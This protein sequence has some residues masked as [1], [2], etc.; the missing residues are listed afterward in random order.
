MCG[1]AGM[2]SGNAGERVDAGVIHR[3]CQAIVHRGPDDEGI[4][5]KD[6]VGLGMRRL[7]IIDIS[8]G[9]QPVFN[10]DRT[11]WVVY[12]GEV[13]NFPELRDDLL[14]KGHHFSTHTDTE[15]IV[16]LYEEMGAD[17]VK[18][19]RGMFAFALFDE[20]RQTLVM[21]RD[22][23]GKKPLHYA[24][25]GNRLLFGSEIKSILAVAPELAEINHQAL[26]HYFY[27]G[28]I[29]D[30]HTAFQKIRKLPPGHLMEFANGRV[31]IRQYWDI[32]EYGT[33]PGMSEEECL[34][35]LESRLQ[36]A[37]RIRLISD[38][39]LGALLS[40]GVDSSIIV[41]L[42]AR[43]SS[44]PVKTFSIG[45]R[46][47]QFNE[48]EYARM[49]AEHFSTDHHELILEPNLE[50]TLTY[51]S[52]IL[53]EPFGDSSMLPT[54]YV[55]RMARERVTVA[56]SGDGGDE[57][58]A[59]YDRYLTALQRSKFDVIPQWVGNFYRQHIH[60]HVP[61]GMYGRN[62]AWNASLAPVDRY[63]DAVGYLPLLDRERGW[64]SADF[65]DR[66]GNLPNPR[67]EFRKYY[68]HGPAKDPLSRLMYLDMKTY[69][70]GDILAKVDR[71]SMASSLEVRVPMLD[72]L[73]VE[74]V[75]GLPVEWKFRSGTRKYILKKLAERLGVPSELLHRRKQG[76]QLP[77]VDWMRSEAK[78]QF[79]QVLL[80]PRAVQ[81]GY[82]KPQAIRALVAE[83]V[84]GRRNRSGVLWRLLVLELWHR[85]FL[86]SK[87]HWGE[88]QRPP[89]I[90]AS[91][92]KSETPAL[93]T[94]G[95][96]NVPTVSARAERSDLPIR[97]AMVGPSLRYVG[98]QSV[99][100]HLLLQRWEQDSEIRA[101]FI[102]VDPFFPAP[103][104]WAEKIPLLRTIL[105]EPIYLRSLWK[106]LKDVDAVHIYS[107]SY[108]SFLLAPLPAW[109]IAK[110]HGKSTLINYHSGEAPDHLRRSHL[111]RHVLANSDAVV[112][113][114]NF[115]V[116]VFRQFGLDAHSI[117]NVVDFSQFRFRLRNPLRP[118]LVCTRGFHPY[119]GI[120]VVVRA[121][122]EVQQTYPDARLDL[123]GGGTLEKEIRE[124]VSNLKLADVHFPGV[125]PYN[126]IA[127]YYDA[128]DIF[129]NGS[130]LDNMPVSILE[131]F[132]AGTPVVTTDPGCM[133]YFVSHEQTGLLSAPGDASALARNIVRV[134][135]S[136]ELAQ[137]LAINAYERSA[138]YDW[139][140]VRE[141]W[142]NMYAKL[143]P[144]FDKSDSTLA[145]IG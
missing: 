41:A 61:A 123:V 124:L 22:R 3:M 2:I 66:V 63:L 48:S 142:R 27:F 68:D 75:A 86:E 58:F 120:D 73:F 118:H 23:L 143:V 103:L 28:Y 91:E 93:S 113:P 137:R 139:P 97:V 88:E 7:S 24:L 140:A 5:V 115:L 129:V 9:H 30:P 47:E 59:G 138:Q 56:L 106:R 53:E 18:K 13:Y 122:A 65:L 69:L 95:F 90:R 11:I 130:N 134:L 70:A 77:L 60:T 141:L 51:L 31:S 125:A 127:R 33:H 111:A 20:R 79:L 78:D 39:P 92:I 29:N 83:H 144:A 98:G 119:Y 74:W 50:E 36:A 21:A 85:N 96:A 105:R 135:Q 4:F 32:P 117:P 112:V 126:E 132:A 25:Q 101:E 17:C 114:S 43:A 40:G 42:M 131:A 52:G 121:F 133:K 44:T 8:G 107:A 109:W 67:D 145:T 15:V 94:A 57:L 54:Y 46:A 87:S 116:E 10:E 100:A 37:V 99:Q 72:H 84:S 128:A 76:F 64:I 102:P 82:L 104:R 34:D 49:V 14:R 12:N 16:H 26:L 89:E 71:M 136:P 45:F 1:I 35:E 81:R 80:E 19:L 110:M 55:S 108:A 6:G 62:L 38:V